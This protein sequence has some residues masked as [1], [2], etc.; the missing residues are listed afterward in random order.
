M[1]L[2]LATG[3]QHKLNE[4]KAILSPYDIEV[5]SLKDF[6]ISMDSVIEDGDTYKANALIKVNYLKDKVDIPVI[7]DDSGMEIEDMN[8]QPGIHSARYASMYG[9][10]D[11][12]IEHI[13][14]ELKDS[15]D[16][17][18]RFICDI[19]LANVTKEP[20]VFEAIV[21]GSI[22]K[23]MHGKQGFG[24]DPIF[25]PNSYDKTYAELSEEEK[26]TISHRAKALMMM[27][28]YLKERKI[29]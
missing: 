16:R 26:N 25:V 27:V 6:D 28:S 20:I 24:Y 2:L 11:K 7:A 1:K 18:A 10:H 15:K 9:G 19:A 13:E 4:V 29:I 12:A 17:K 8:N 3:N 21:N 22:A 23:E 5:L 14:E